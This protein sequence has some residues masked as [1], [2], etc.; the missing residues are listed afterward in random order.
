MVDKPSP[1]FMGDMLRG[2]SIRRT[3]PRMGTADLQPS[4]F[5]HI[6]LEQYVTVDHPMRKI[7]PL[8][9]T[10]RIRQLCAVREAITQYSR[11]ESFN[12]DQGCQFTGLE[13]MNLLKDQGIQISMD[14]RGCWRDNVFVERLWRSLK[15]EEVYLHAYKTVHDAHQGVA[16]YV[17]FYNQIRPHRA[18]DRRTPDR[19]YWEKQHSQPSVA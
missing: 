12:T 14:G 1:A 10:A 13:L 9:D 16:R 11:P 19:M 15:Y 6:N 2:F 5:Y 17:T 3:F 8:I 4:M 18:L 7:R